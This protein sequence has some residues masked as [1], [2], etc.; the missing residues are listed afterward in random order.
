[1]TGS[2]VDDSGG[3]VSRDTAMAVKAT[4]AVT[5]VAAAETVVSETMTSTAMPEAVAETG[6]G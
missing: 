6:G 5:A 3:E 4:V 1:M 2:G